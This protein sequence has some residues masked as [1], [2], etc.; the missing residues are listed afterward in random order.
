MRSTAH[1]SPA[2][3]KAPKKDTKPRSNSR[4]KEPKESQGNGSQEAAK[5]SPVPPPV[6]END[7]APNEKPVDEDKSQES[8]ESRGNGQETAKLSPV[9][10][11]PKQNDAPAEHPATDEGRNLVAH[12]RVCKLLEHPMASYLA[13]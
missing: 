6:P 11:G 12:S 7:K 1:A 8:K 5:Q 10:A 13:D 4:A 9:P 3:D 2:P